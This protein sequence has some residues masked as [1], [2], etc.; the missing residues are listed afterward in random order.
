LSQ[1]AQ[2]IQQTTVLL[3]PSWLSNAINQI[4]TGINADINLQGDP[5]NDQR[6][7]MET[8]GLRNYFETTKQ[9]EHQTV[10]EYFEWLLAT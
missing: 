10:Y 2:W 3:D 9:K 4:M 7:L 8:A 6:I 1:N 5:V